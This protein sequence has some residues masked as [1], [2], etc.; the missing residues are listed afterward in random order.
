MNRIQQYVI[1]LCVLF[2]GKY[3]RKVFEKKKQ[4]HKTGYNNYDCLP[5]NRRIDDSQTY[6]PTPTYTHTAFF[7]YGMRFADYDVGT[8]RG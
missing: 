2:S 1:L 3:S 4:K 7:L 8:A 6:K 5:T